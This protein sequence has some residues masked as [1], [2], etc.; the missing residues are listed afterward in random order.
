MDA[1]LNGVRGGAGAQDAAQGSQARRGGVDADVDR[2]Q[3][4]AL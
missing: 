3:G 2:E 1:N 4:D